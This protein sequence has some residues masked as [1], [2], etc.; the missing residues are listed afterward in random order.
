MI[1]PEMAGTLAQIFPVGILILGL[2]LRQIPLPLPGTPGGKVVIVAARI[3]V[4]VALVLAL[5]AE[6]SL[7]S[8]VITARPV[9][10][11]LISISGYA[12]AYA[13]GLLLVYSAMDALGLA[14]ALS[15]F[16]LRRMK[17]KRPKLYA[18]LLDF[19]AAEDQRKG[20]ARDDTL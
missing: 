2:E 11:L 1:S 3:F 14:D 10:S 8:A 19:I 6:T 12:L 17:R 18:K 5:N 4:V 20:G 13:V 9:D 7:V 15:A 16:G